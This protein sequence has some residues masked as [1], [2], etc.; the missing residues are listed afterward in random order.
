MS[1]TH[2]IRSLDPTRCVIITSKGDG[3]R[4]QWQQE[5][6]RVHVISHW[7][8][9]E[10]KLQRLLM[11]VRNGL[12]LSSLVSQEEAEIVLLNDFRPLE[13]AW[14][15][16][17][18]RRVP[19][20]F[21]VR[22][23]KRQGDSYDLRWKWGTRRVH[24]VLA[25]SEEMVRTLA[26][27]LPIDAGIATTPH[28]GRVTPATSIY[29]TVPWIDDRTFPSDRSTYMNRTE[30]PDPSLVLYIGAVCPKKGQLEFLNHAA[31]SILSVGARICF[32]GDFKPDQNDYAAACRRRAEQLEFSGNLKFMGHVDDLRHW[33]RQ[34]SLTVLASKREGMARAMIESLSCGTPMVSFAV[35]SA[36][37]ILHGNHAGIVVPEGDYAALADAVV[38]LLRDPE[39]RARLGRNGAITAERLFAPVRVRDAYVEL[40]RRLA[41]SNHQQD[42]M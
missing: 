7:R 11:L 19:L 25:L 26:D 41:T 38:G 4:S 21:N 18:R 2:V 24:H 3:R 1:I 15:M 16:L 30:A 31:S 8:D 33:Y 22:D 28:Q 27:H 20:I 42:D 9:Y 29:S 37:E 5:G 6:L 14:P 34:A 36:R 10:G 32:L 13:Q 35:T 39:R 23:T 40:F 12:K 17:V